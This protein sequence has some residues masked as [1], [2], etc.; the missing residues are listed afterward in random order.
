[1][2]IQSNAKENLD[3]YY[4]ERFHRPSRQ[5]PIENPYSFQDFATDND[6]PPLITTIFMNPCDVIKAYFGILQDAS[7]MMGYLGGCGS[8]GDSILPYSYAYELFTNETQSKMPLSE[9]IDS[10]KGI[11]HIL[12]LNLLPAYIPPTMPPNICYFMFETELITGPSVLDEVAYNR[13]GTSFVYQ[14]GL[15]TV[16][17][18][19]EYGWK[20]KS[21]HCLPED[22]LC[23]PWHGWIYSSE[24]VVTFVYKDWYQL[25]NGID[26]IRQCGNLIFVY[27]SGEGIQYRFDFIRLTNGY[28]ILLHENIYIDGAWQE[29]NI[30]KPQDQQMRLSIL[31]PNLSK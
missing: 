23:A 27:A 16:E 11:G 22:F 28:D 21:I 10:F 19:S 9:F 20:I 17:Y 24:Y 14:Y 13:G 7:N 30:L 12:L 3:N 31:N 1:M 15:I 8:I 2:Q 26:H 18:H 5:L 29:T 6:S 4:T 25:I